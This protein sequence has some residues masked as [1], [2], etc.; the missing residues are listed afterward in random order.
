MDSMLVYRG[1]NIGTAKPSER[2]LQGVPHHAVDLIDPCEDFNV[3]RYVDLAM[4]AYD[5]CKGAL[6]GVGGTPFYLKGLRDELG[7]VQVPEALEKTLAQ[8]TTDHLRRSL[9]RL[10]PLRAEKILPN[11][12]FRLVRAIALI[13]ASGIRASELPHDHPRENTQ[14][15]V[16][17]LDCDRSIMHPLL[18]LRIERMF[19]AGLLEEARELFEGPPLSRTAMAGVGYK[20][21]FAH[22]RGECS[23]EEA[24]HRI[25]VGTRRLFKHQMTWLRK[26]DVTW[27]KAHPLHPELAWPKVLA[28]A[29]SHFGQKGDLSH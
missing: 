2:E 20:E 21:L 28:L 11:D 8:A 6:V 17:A 9:Q 14:V 16:V 18:E 10:D 1:M 15:T 22:F 19:V 23:L 7:E 12:R 13:Y 27:V 26:M 24:K 3:S 5:R 4:E 25:L 29:E